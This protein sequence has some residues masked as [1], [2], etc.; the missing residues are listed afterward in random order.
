MNF[1]EDRIKRY[2]KELNKHFRVSIVE[3]NNNDISLQLHY[4]MFPNLYPKWERYEIIN[5]AEVSSLMQV[6]GWIE[7]MREEH[8]I[9]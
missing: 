2:E 4:N 9:E 7:E 8:E 1:T 5:E 3:W 6:Y